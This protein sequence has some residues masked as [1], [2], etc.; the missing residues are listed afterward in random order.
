MEDLE[1]KTRRLNR[2]DFGKH[3]T[4]TCIGRQVQLNRYQKESLVQEAC[5]AKSAGLYFVKRICCRI[6]YQSIGTIIIEWQTHFKAF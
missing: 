3:P 1:R 6:A 2:E 5:V 4:L